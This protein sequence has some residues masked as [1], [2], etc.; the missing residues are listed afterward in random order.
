MF[1]NNYSRKID[2]IKI[3][4]EARVST[5]KRYI[6]ESLV[7]VYA[8]LA[9]INDMIVRHMENPDRKNMSNLEE[10]LVSFS[11]HKGIYDQIRYI[12]KR[13]NEVIRISK[14]DSG[15]SIISGDKLQNKKHRTY[16]TSTIALEKGMVFISPLD[17]NMENDVVETP[18]KPVIRFAVPSID[19]NGATLGIVVVNFLAQS[20]FNRLPDMRSKTECCGNMLLNRDGYWLYSER[21]SDYTYSFM[22]PE[23]EQIRI[24]DFF[25]DE[26]EEIYTADQGVVSTGKGIFLWNSIS[27]ENV[28][29]GFSDLK[30]SGM[31][32]TA[33]DLYWKNISHINQGFL[34][35]IRSETIGDVFSNFL[36][37]LIMNLVISLLIAYLFYRN[38]SQ[39]VHMQ[40]LATIDTLTGLMNRQFFLE[41]AAKSLGLVSRN[42]EMAALLFMDLDGFKPINDTYGHDAGDYV[43][44]EVA[45]QLTT[46]L[47]QSDL[48]ARFGGDEFT[49]L[50]LNL[51]TKEDIN[52][53]VS[54]VRSGLEG[55][56]YFRNKKFSIGCSIGCAFYPEDGE[57]IQKLIER[58]DMKMYEDKRKRKSFSWEP[59]EER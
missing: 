43:L 31:L 34:D 33:E 4:E 48:S 41:M 23:Q 30:D 44:K 28:P 35:E 53:I 46:T 10:N 21:F 8:D 18:H 32:K 57:T 52:L 19:S 50:L 58:A 59:G 5:V 27:P 39:K 15:A 9:F 25:P 16:F 14:T 20:I 11:I 51:K 45:S 56:L 22:F 54:K 29:G 6:E 1:Q 12:D 36:F 38:R 7:Q 26:A 37:I 40:H 3:N 49:M 24:Y 2:E 55:S 47:R 42:S 13:G 17:L